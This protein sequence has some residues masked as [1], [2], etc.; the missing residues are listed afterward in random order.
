LLFVVDPV[1][2]G[3]SSELA[4]GE[5]VL[6][7]TS[8]ALSVPHKRQRSLASQESEALPLSWYLRLSKDT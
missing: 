4:I 5:L 6:I 2:G 7:E 8:S 1:D 3:M